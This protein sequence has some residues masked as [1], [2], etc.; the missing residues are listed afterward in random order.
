MGE[1]V[2]DV[3][4]CGAQY[5]LTRPGQRKM[6]EVA[7]KCLADMQKRKEVPK[8]KYTKKEKVVE[9][10]KYVKKEKVVAEKPKRKYVKKPVVKKATSKRKREII[11]I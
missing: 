1:W 8:R 10:R 5:A 7:A 9:K 4:Y 2:K 3:K 6:D 11:N